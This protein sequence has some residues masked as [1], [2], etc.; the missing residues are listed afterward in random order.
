MAPNPAHHHHRR[1][2]R[3]SL[4]LVQTNCA[5]VHGFDREFR[6]VEQNCEYSESESEF[7]EPE[8]DESARKRREHALEQQTSEMEVVDV[9]A[10]VTDGILPPVP[11]G[12]ITFLP[13][14]IPKDTPV[15][16]LSEEEGDD[17][18]KVIAEVSASV[19]VDGGNS[20]SRRRSRQPA[21]G[22]RLPTTKRYGR[23]PATKRAGGSRRSRKATRPGER[24]EVG[25]MEDTRTVDT[26]TGSS[27]VEEYLQQAREMTQTSVGA[28]AEEDMGEM[29][30]QESQDAD[31]HSLESVEELVG[32]ASDSRSQSLEME[33]A[34]GQVSLLL[35]LLPLQ[36]PQ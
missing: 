9:E 26:P 13:V 4:H 36:C 27:L 14:V 16:Y 33:Q 6:E 28:S 35:L 21:T 8:E 11:P 19:A 23:A 2:L 15:V 5:K 22:K 17:D 31:Q 25:T 1:G 24:L 20:T 32:D 30:S 34:M 10:P 7:D 12:T 3:V 29:G 18:G